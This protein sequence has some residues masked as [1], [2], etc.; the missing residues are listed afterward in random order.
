MGANILFTGPST[1]SEASLF[2]LHEASQGLGYIK[3]LT[4]HLQKP[5]TG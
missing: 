1:V 3:R 4:G 2:S 5:L